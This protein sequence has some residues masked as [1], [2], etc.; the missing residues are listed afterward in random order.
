MPVC[1]S[2]YVFSE[3]VH[4]LIQYVNQVRLKLELG[5]CFIYHSVL[6]VNFFSLSRVDISLM[7]GL[8]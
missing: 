4:I 7:T 3:H 6:I 1:V 5:Q 8:K 2:T